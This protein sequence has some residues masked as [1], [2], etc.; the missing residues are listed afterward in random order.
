MLECK[1]RKREKNEE[2]TAANERFYEMAVVAP[3]KR[4]CDFASF[5]PAQTAVEAATS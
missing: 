3:H 2:S 4:Q 1:M 5:T